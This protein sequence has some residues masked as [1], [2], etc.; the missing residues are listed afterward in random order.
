[1][2]RTCYHRLDSSSCMYVY[3]AVCMLSLSFP[4]MREVCYDYD[5]LL[6]SGFGLCLILELILTG[7]RV[8]FNQF[9]ISIIYFQTN[10]LLTFFLY[11][12]RCILI[13]FG[14]HWRKDRVDH[15]NGAGHLFLCCSLLMIY[16][17]Y[18]SWGKVIEIGLILEWT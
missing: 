17:G 2:I 15:D 13:S 18:V 10:T 4:C 5:V 12:C 6:L 3:Y 11:T 14:Q 7:T 1:M 8:P 16:Y 9:N